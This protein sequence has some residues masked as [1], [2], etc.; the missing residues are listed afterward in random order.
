MLV[1]SIPFSD[2]YSS[3]EKKICQE[4]TKT[5]PKREKNRKRKQIN[6]PTKSQKAKRKKR[7]QLGKE[8]PTNKPEK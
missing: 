5:A 3:K 2:S 1:I 4:Y 7:N 8:A 6:K